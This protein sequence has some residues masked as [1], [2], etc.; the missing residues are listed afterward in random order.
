MNCYHLQQNAFSAC[1]EMRDSLPITDQNG[2]V[3]CPK[4]RRLGVLMNMPVLPLRWHLSQQAEGFDSKAGAEL[5][6][7]ILK[8]ESY[9][10]EFPN[11]QYFCGSPPVRAANPLTQDARFGDEEHTRTSTISSPSG[12]MSPSSASHK[13]GCARMKLGLKPA[14]VRVEGFDCLSRD[15]QNSGIPAVA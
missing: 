11:L 2:P 3:I 6:D 14:A 15:C 9:G 7:I 1:E 4:P 13:G 8:R 12:L 5:L 10:E